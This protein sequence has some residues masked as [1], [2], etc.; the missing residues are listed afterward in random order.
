VI[1]KDEHELLLAA[2]KAS[3]KTSVP[4]ITHTEGMLGDEQQKIL[5]QAGVPAYRIIIGH[6]CLS[7]DFDYHLRIVQG[8]SYLGFDRFGMEGGMPDEVRVE[9]MLKLIDAGCAARLIAAHDSVWY[10]ESGPQPGSGA[11]KNW[12]PTN[13]FERIIP[14]LRAGGATDAHIWTI[15]CDNPR[16][17]FA[18]EHPEPIN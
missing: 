9:S 18:G 11:Y 4:V 3:V 15:L 1:G 16:R 13:F 5:T 7:T 14:M 6:S 8:G 2:A 12:K 17:F 10:W